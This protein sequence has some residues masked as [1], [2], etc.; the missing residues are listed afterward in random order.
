MVDSSKAWEPDPSFWRDRPV[1]V[2]GATGFLGSHLTALLVDLGAQVVVLTRDEVAPSPIAER[3]VGKVA[4]VRGAVEDQAAVERLLGEYEVRSLF[5]LAAQSQVGVANRNPV[6]TL[7]A[8]VAGT[9]AV[10]DAARRSPRLEQ[11]VT[12][13]SDKAYGAQ[14]VL[15]Y[16]EEMPLLAV[17][18]YDVSKACADLV[19]QSFQRTFDVPVSI[20]RCG[21]FFGPGDRNWERLVP[22]TIRSLLRGERPVIR[23]D[24]TM[25]RDYLYVVDG[26]LAYLMLV[27][28]MASDPA[29]IGEAFNFSTETPLNVLE[30]VAMLQGAAGTD[31]EP[32]VQATAT[33]EIDSQFLSAE[34]ARKVLGWSPTLSVE[35]A[36]DETVA[37]YRS[38]LGAAR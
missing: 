32:D 38:Y 14:P 22:G 17:N 24:G 7:E 2:T 10:L 29:V 28:A 36:L 1:A 3:W 26:A 19:S 21:N 18:P 37:W 20:T 11:V 35:D 25:V 31:L 23:S 33:H 16:D 5:H 30:L 15:P 27:E 12:A 9:W 13:S 34:K 4:S 6:S 8:N